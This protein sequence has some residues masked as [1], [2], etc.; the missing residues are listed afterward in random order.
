MR[1]ARLALLPGQ[2]VA[3]AYAPGQVLRVKVVAAD[4]RAGHIELA[5]SSKKGGDGDDDGDAAGGDGKAAAGKEEKGSKADKDKAPKGLPGGFKPGDVVASAKVAAVEA[6]DGGR[7]VVRLEV[8]APGGGGG[9]AA[10]VA[11][12]L[13]AAHLSDHPA[14]AE[15]LLEQLKPGVELPGPFLVLGAAPSEGG[16]GKK[17][18]GKKAGAAAG[19]GGAALLLTRKASMAAAA[20]A[21]PAAF[22]AVSRGAR[23]PGYVAH[24]TGDAVFVRFLG[25]VTGR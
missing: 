11:A 1:K 4:A 9:D 24:V 8:A 12:R 17:G 14:A 20:G 10:A 2:K 15:Q 25:G 7:A 22:E 13:P 23:L 3:D 5:L 21:L 16:K 6:K 19:A 18:K